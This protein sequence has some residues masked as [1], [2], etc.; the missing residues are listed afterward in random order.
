MLMAGGIPPLN[1][2]SISR[3]VLLSKNEL[4]LQ[5]FLQWLKFL[6]YYLNS[7]YH[8]K[9]KTNM[10]QEIS[11]NLYLNKDIYMKTFQSFYSHV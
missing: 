11:E 7:S 9:R 3:N 4:N 1:W 8:I 10:L 2:I 5:V 6:Q